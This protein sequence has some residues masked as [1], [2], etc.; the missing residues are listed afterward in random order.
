V[1][2]EIA[3]NKSGYCVAIFGGG[4]AGTEAAFRLSQLGIRVVLF[5]QH[6]LPYGKIEEGLPK[7]HIKLR[8]QEEAKID[9]KLNQSGIYFVPDTKLGGDLS[10]SEIQS[11]G[12]NAILLAVGAWRDRPFPVG[13]IEKY[14]GRG[15]CYQNE[16]VSS[17]NHRHEPNY[18]G[19]LC[20]IPD[21]TI[22]IGGGLA[23]F[24]VMKILML[25]T[26]GNALAS[27]G[28]RYDVFTLER[29]GIDL[30]LK[31]HKLTLQQ[32]GLKGS[33]LYYRRRIVDMPLSPLSVKADLARQE[34]VFGLRRRIAQNFTQKYLFK[35]KECC[36]PIDILVKDNH[37]AGLVFQ[38]TRIENNH[39]IPIAD[40]RFEVQSSLVIS[41]IGSIPEPAREI[42]MEGG[43]LSIEDPESGK[44]R[45][46]D[47]VFAVG[48][49][50]TGRGNIRESLLHSREIT[51]QLVENYFDLTEENFN[52]FIQVQEKTID[53]AIFR[54]SR[55]LKKQ[56]PI[57][58]DA[59]SRILEKTRSLQQKV[60]YGGNYKEW[61]FKHIPVR[62]EDLMS[63]DG[64]NK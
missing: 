17:F 64:E 27:R 20:E 62:L 49:A 55:V 26:A 1:N 30:I 40:S 23:S 48:N 41:S 15:F 43:L 63:E 33:T 28:I 60:G 39:I 29:D 12:F 61:I 42:P 59:I 21:D 16:F 6:A 44:V 25:E 31:K 32:L 18:S 57:S 35:I 24:D 38:R 22:V 9:E 10:L 36:V 56:K 14:R 37:L 4:V 52:E 47:N 8:E 50:V 11:W 7:W 53:R 34:K 45:G 2:N 5:E 19:P 46:F 3:V 51:E 54:I 58:S 13:G